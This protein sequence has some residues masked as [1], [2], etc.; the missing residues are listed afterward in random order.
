MKT[1]NFAFSIHKSGSSLFFGILHEVCTESTQ[2]NSG[3]KKEYLSIP[4]DLFNRG[5]GEAPL[6]E[7]NFPATHGVSFNNPD[8]LY[9]GFRWVPAFFQGDIEKH[10]RILGLVR[11]PRD[12]LTS[13]YFSMLKSHIVPKGE[14]GKAMQKRRKNLANVSI[15][16]FMNNQIRAGFW[17]ER[18]SRLT[19][20]TRHPASKFW[21]YEDVVFEKYQWLDEILDH[22]Q[23]S[24]PLESKESIILKRDIRPA[25]EDINK[26]IRKVTPGDHRDKLKA[27]TIKNLN[28]YFSE[29]LKFWGYL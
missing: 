13:H 4:D 26:H 15:D 21:R 25:K 6:R 12:V 2:L 19:E 5:L 18:L 10:A 14:K 28:S 11:D 22:L 27:S 3:N 16:D 8:I 20:L 23:M 7:I 9:G 29:L 24:L 17:H 1:I